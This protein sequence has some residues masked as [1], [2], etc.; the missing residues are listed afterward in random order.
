MLQTVRA[1]KVDEKMESFVLFLCVLPELKSFSCPKK[2]YF[3]QFSADLIE[4]SKSIKAFYIL[5][6]SERSGNTLS[7]NS[8]A[9]YAIIYF[10]EDSWVWSR[11]I[12]LNFCWVSIFFDILIANTSWTV[13]QTQFNHI[14]LFPKKSN[15]NFQMHICKL[16]QHLDSLLRSAQHSRKCTFMDN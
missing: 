3:L 2:M 12:L 1:E 6:V 7:E 14:T 11:R 15:E 4:K 16:P 8:I 13:A 10:L 9:Y 5:Y